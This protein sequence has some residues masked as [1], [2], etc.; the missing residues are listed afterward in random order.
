MQMIKDTV[1]KDSNKRQSFIAKNGET[2]ESQVTFRKLITDLYFVSYDHWPEHLL[3][4]V[5]VISFGLANSPKF[6]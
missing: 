6:Q 5:T 4:M 3:L 1:I 2:S